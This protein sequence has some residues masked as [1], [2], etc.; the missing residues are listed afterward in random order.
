[1]TA[2]APRPTR[3][4][5]SH[6]VNGLKAGRPTMG[7]LMVTH[8]RRLLDYIRPDRVHVMQAR[9]CVLALW[10]VCVCVCG[11]VGVPHTAPCLPAAHVAP[12][13]SY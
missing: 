5:V 2:F 1:M 7:V 4:D 10:C 6:A 9:I 8:Y 11:W 13:P 12:P 3:S